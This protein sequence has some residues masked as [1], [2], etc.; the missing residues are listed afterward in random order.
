MT[1][2]VA[3]EPQEVR[4]LRWRMIGLLYFTYLCYYLPRKAD[5]IT[6]SSLQSDLKFSLEDLALA[7]TS[8]LLTYTFALFASGMVGSRIPSNFML[9]GGLCGVA[10]CS[11]LKSMAT[12]PMMFCVVQA[13]HAVFQSTGWPTCIKV[14]ATYVHPATR[15]TTMGF[16]TTCQSLGGV[17][18]T[19]AGTWFLTEYHSWVFAY[20]YH[21]PILVIMAVADLMLIRDDPPKELSEYFAVKHEPAVTPAGTVESVEEP[22]NITLSQVVALPGVLQVGTSYFFLKFLRYALLF[23][24]PF[25]YE[26]ELGYD[27]ST[28]SLVS[29]SFELGG[30]IGTPL[31]GYVS[32]Q[33]MN[34]KRDLTA[35]LFMGAAS[36]TLLAC[37]VLSGSGPAINGLC[38]F[39]TGIL[40]IGP[41]SV[42]SGTLAQDIGQRSKLGKGAVGSVA[43]LLNS[44]GSAGSVFQS[45]ATAYISK[46][47]GWDALFLG[48]VSCSLASAGILIQVANASKPSNMPW[49]QFLSPT[50]KAKEEGEEN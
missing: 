14:L 33:Y 7:D 37:I 3:T 40:V 43:G 23:W 36:L 17:A 38:M 20:Q 39:L 34:S 27:R 28:S 42:L 6:K 50:R 22:T 13:L 11:L 1:H 18:G 35:G 5:A 16:W 4:N 9:F 41:D 44:M 46:Q 10:L 24:L 47:F 19:I 25:Y 26:T 31:I 32:D 45:G 12:T 48:F 8:Y 15:G 30:T 21:I 49:V 29:T 2:A